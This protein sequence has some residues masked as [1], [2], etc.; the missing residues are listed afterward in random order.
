MGLFGIILLILFV[1][2]CILLVLLVVVQD[3]NSQGLGGIFGG[4][5]DTTFGSQS[6]NIM[7]KIT[8][9]VGAAFL[10]LAF[11]LGFLSRTPESPDLLDSIQNDVVE[12]TENWW[13]E[14]ETDNE[15]E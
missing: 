12:Q 11:G 10:V 1:I 6:G 14:A 13:N 8:Y 4:A 5:S 2:V 3:E 9:I 7:T 15:T